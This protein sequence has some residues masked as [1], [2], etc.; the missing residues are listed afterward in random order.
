VFFRFFRDG[1]NEYLSR[2]WL[3][4][5]GEVDAKVEEKRQ[6]GQWNGEFYV[7]FGHGHTRNWDDA[8]KYGFI[9]AGGGPWYSR[10]LSILEP[11]ARFWANIP[12]YGYAG[13]GIVEEPAMPI[14]EFKIN[15]L[16]GK[17]VPITSQ[18]LSGT[19][20]QEEAAADETKTEHFVRV[21]WLKTVPLSE[22]FRE[23]GFFGNQNS[24][25]KPRAKSWQHTVERL[26][27]RFGIEE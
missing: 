27:Q 21:R 14:G 6:K 20:H 26:K 3:I 25:A 23:K 4:D 12:G 19:Y 9:S 2:A 11:G 7:S 15:D 5:P 17:A 1:D 13:V 8:R 22:A 16:E 10:T 24:A 18:P